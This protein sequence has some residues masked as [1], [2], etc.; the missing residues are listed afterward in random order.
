M[1]MLYRF[2]YCVFPCLW[3]LSMVFFS[4][5]CHQ[6]LGGYV[7]VLNL[8]LSP[9]LPFCHVSTTLLDSNDLSCPDLEL[10]LPLCGDAANLATIL[11]V[12]NER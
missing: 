5:P 6:L 7:G 10:Y 12:R 4:T 11:L 1:W 9:P 8:G 3:Y 2:A